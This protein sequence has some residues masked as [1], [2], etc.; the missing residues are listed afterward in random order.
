M[1]GDHLGCCDASGLKKPKCNFPSRYFL[2]QKTKLNDINEQKKWRSNPFDLW[3][4]IQQINST[5][6]EKLRNANGFK[7]EKVRHFLIVY[8]LILLIIIIQSQHY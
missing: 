8:L 5:E 7:K 1:K 4:Q 2:T 6:S 3:N